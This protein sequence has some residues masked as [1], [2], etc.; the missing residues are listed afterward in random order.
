MTEQND[1]LTDTAFI[2]AWLARDAE[3]KE[4][5]ITVT[6]E[7]GIFPLT[8]TGEEL[9]RKYEQYARRAA[10]TR[11]TSARLVRFTRG[12]TLVELP[13]EVRN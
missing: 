13:C 12:E 11:E 7:A 1:G 8:F 9:A 4:G 2:Y 6:S 5:I 10:R 3:D